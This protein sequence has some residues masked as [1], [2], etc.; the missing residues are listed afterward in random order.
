[1]NK[2]NF[3]SARNKKNL[4]LAI[5]GI[6]G[7][8]ICACGA[9][10]S[11]DS[12]GSKFDPIP[13]EAY[14]F[15]ADEELVSP[16]YY[17]GKYCAV[18][19][20]APAGH[21]ERT[22]RQFIL[23]GE[24]TATKGDVT[25][26]AEL[27]DDPGDYSDG[28]FIY[29]GDEGEK[30]ISFSTSYVR[31]TYDPGRECE[32]SIY[33]KYGPSKKDSLGKIYGAAYFADVSTGDDIFGQSVKVR[34][35]LVPKKNY[36]T[37]Y[38]IMRG[39]GKNTPNRNGGYDE[40]DG[41]GGTYIDPFGHMPVFVSEGDK[42]WFVVDMIDGETWQVGM[43]NLF[44]FTWVLDPDKPPYGTAP[45]EEESHDSVEW[46]PTEHPGRWD[47]TDV[48]YTGSR[49]ASTSKNGV[50][51]AAERFGVDGQHMR[52]T[53]DGREKYYM[54]TSIFDSS[55]YASGYFSETVSIYPDPVSD[56]PVGEPRCIFCL[57]DVEMDQ[58]GAI[59]AF[60]PMHYFTQFLSD[61]SIKAFSPG[62]NGKEMKWREYEKKSDL[63]FKGSFPEGKTDGEKKY[64]VY[65]AR[66]SVTGD[67]SLYNVYEYTY[68]MGP[69]TEWM[70]NSPGY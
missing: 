3:F 22:D 6:I 66:D 58:D 31:E 52:F 1:M 48:I 69:V 62:P 37:G 45:E 67:C 13:D 28:F 68:T 60:E 47:L 49:E 36:G 53:F 41:S 50:T 40:K 16:S 59:T 44:E 14:E 26:T 51:A 21:W 2:S 29:N 9:E 23:S 55:Y 32:P 56:D 54:P 27:S 20:G 42:I 4:A 12:G 18:S 10:A 64:L 61:D 39:F 19:K 7:L 38:Q 46:T 25:V 11:E 70:Y 15:W 35:Y 43:R 33:L 8:S 57:A 24:T 63:N 17:D 5:A 34:E 65:G 30:K